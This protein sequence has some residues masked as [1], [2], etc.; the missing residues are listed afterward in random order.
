MEFGR[1][2]GNLALSRAIGDF[3]FKNNTQLP[4]EKQI[5]TVNPEIIDHRLDH[6]VEYIVI[7]CDGIWDCISNEDLVYFISERIVAGKDM[8]TICEEVVDF[9]LAPNT[10]IGAVGMLAPISDTFII[11]MRQHVDY[12]YGHVTGSFKEGVGRGC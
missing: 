11:R 1:V 10:F 7:A 3:E 12:Y 8:V 2:N 9:C 4:A 5:V 6:S